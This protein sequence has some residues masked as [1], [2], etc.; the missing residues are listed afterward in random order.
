M[1]ASV[2]QMPMAENVIDEQLKEASSEMLYLWNHHKVT[3]EVQAKLTALGFGDAE[4]FSKIADTAADVREVVHE[5]LGL[6]NDLGIAGRSI[7]A[8]VLA[9]WEAAVGG[10]PSARPLTLSK[11]PWACQKHCHSRFMMR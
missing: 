6:R 8:R 2:F 11:P 5:E 3:R 9:A 10:A 7:T 4:V 1:A